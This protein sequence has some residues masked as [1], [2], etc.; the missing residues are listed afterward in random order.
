MKILVAGDYCP[1]GRVTEMLDNSM[2]NG[3]FGGYTEVLKE[4]DFSI[5]NL[6]CP[7][8]NSSNGILKTGPLLK[9]E[10][11]QSLISLKELGF[12]LLTLANNHILDY[13]Q[14]G[15]LDTIRNA[16]GVGLETVGAGE[17]LEIASRPYIVNLDNQSVGILNMAENEFCGA[18]IHTAGAFTFDL[19]SILTIIKNIRSTVDKVILIYHGG[20]EHYNL[21]TPEIRRRFR[22][23]IDSGVDAIV[24]H[25]THCIGGFEYYKDKPIVYSLGNFLF[26]Y[27]VKYQKGEWI[28]GYC[29]K[30]SSLDKD[31]PFKID[32]IP[33]MQ[34]EKSDFRLRLLIGEEKNLV[35]DKIYGLNKIIKDDDKFFQSWYS[36]LISQRTFYLSS[37]MIKNKYLRYLFM[38]RFLPS[39]FLYSRHNRL[40]LNLIRC[41]THHEILKNILIIENENSNIIK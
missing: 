13:S 12:D 17:N 15:V 3:L 16:H 22:F 18:T 32:F 29:V 37:L 27:K 4:M 14:D 36:Y 11:L 24:A 26:D 33:H 19:I 1:I 39:G 25:H 30:L 10:N 9:S 5:I 41:E 38:L 21:P 28:Y 31:S 8:T 7:V 20:R 34:G 2:N 6:E 40:V 35:L 23:L